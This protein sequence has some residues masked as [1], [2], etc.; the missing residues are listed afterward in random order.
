LI[1]KL[2]TKEASQRLGHGG[3]GEIKSHPWFERINF[4]LLENKKLRPPFVP[5]LKSE[6]D[7]DNFDPD[8][9]NSKVHSYEESPGIADEVAF[10]NFTFD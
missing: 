8:F 2:L 9:T 4:K 10:E 1:Q 6:T 7:T 5:I 3:A